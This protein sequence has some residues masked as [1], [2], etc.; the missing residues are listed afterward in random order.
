MAVTFGVVGL[1][2]VCYKDLGAL[3][4]DKGQGPWVYTHGQEAGVFVERFKKSELMVATVAPHP[5][6]LKIGRGIGK[7]P[8]L[9]ADLPH[10]A[11]QQS[12]SGSQ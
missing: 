9:L 3:H 5:H 1:L 12:S 7:V 6:V 4:P 8:A 10:V 2:E 11:H